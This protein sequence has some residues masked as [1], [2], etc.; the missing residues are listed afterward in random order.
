MRSTDVSGTLAPAWRVSA[1]RFLTPYSSGH[2]RICH[3][4]VKSV[5]DELRT[6]FDIVAESLRVDIHNMVDWMKANINGVTKLE[7]DRN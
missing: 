4:S 3:F 1:R 5:R 2:R 6:H 7:A